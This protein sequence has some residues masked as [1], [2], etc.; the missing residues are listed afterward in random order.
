[1]GVPLVVFVL[2]VR[3]VPAV[4]QLESFAAPVRLAGRMAKL[5]DE[6]TV[7]VGLNVGYL[8]R[9]RTFFQALLSENA[10]DF[11]PKF[12]ALKV[13]TLVPPIRGYELQEPLAALTSSIATS[14]V[15]VPALPASYMANYTVF[16]FLY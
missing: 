16:W 2:S 13:T 5:S 6:Q 10:M 4:V 8:M 11:L 1:M 9:N 3:V 15:I 14:P 12:S 7:M